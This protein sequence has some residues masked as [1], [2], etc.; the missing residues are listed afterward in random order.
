MTDDNFENGFFSSNRRKTDDI[1]SFT[2]DLVQ[3]T[4]CDSMQ[5]NNYCFLFYDE[6]QNENDSIPVKYE[7]DFG[8]GMK[9]T[10]LKVKHCFPG[11]GKYEVK[12]NIIESLRGDSIL[13]R[14]SYKFEL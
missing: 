10:G 14:N 4:H 6:F 3:F 5:K 9:K 8:N 12:L 13:G 1:F 2:E 11:P 7:W